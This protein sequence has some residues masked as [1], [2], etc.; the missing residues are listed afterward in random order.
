M[1]ADPARTRQIVINLLGNAL[2]YSAGEVSVRAWAAGPQVR[3]EVEDRGAGMS[4]AQIV[5]AFEP[6]ERLG[7]EKGQVKGSGLGLAVCRRLARLMGGD[8]TV[9]S[10]VGL[11]SVFVLSLPAHSPENV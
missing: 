5:R 2:K 7:Q 8:V 6:F 3:L 1:R 9:H 10:E 4:A 11:G